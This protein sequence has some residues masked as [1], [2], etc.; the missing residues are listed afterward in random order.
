MVTDEQMRLKIGI[1]SNVERLK[2]YNFPFDIDILGE[3]PDSPELLEI[4]CFFASFVALAP[5]F[6]EQ[7]DRSRVWFTQREPSTSLTEVLE[8]H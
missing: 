3:T 4:A 5:H 7:M 6:V 8:L 1:L 2:E